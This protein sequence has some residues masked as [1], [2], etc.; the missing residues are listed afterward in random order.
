MGPD[1]RMSEQSLNYDLSLSC[2]CKTATLS[3]IL[4]LSAIIVMLSDITFGNFLSD[5]IFY[6]AEVLLLY[7]HR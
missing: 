2:Y 4:P 1:A 6:I 5:A 3:V 7:F